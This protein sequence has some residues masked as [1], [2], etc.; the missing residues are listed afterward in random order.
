MESRANKILTYYKNA[1]YNLTL[2]SAI[3]VL[4]V[5]LIEIMILAYLGTY[6]SN[7]NNLTVTAFTFLALLFTLT[8]LALIHKSKSTWRLLLSIP[9]VLILGFMAYTSIHMIRIIFELGWLKCESC[10]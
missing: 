10:P 3:A 6:H 8:I 2:D 1:T 7:L 9:I 4:I 5:G